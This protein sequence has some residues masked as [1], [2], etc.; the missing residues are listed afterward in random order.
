MKEEKTIWKG[1]RSQWTNLG[2]YIFCALTFYLVI[3]VIAGFITY[4]KTKY[5]TYKITDERIIERFGIFSKT[6]D[7]LEL[8]RIRDVRQDEPFILGLFGMVNII[9]VTTDR[10][11]GVVCLKGVPKSE[12]LK[13]KIRDLIKDGAQRR[14]LDIV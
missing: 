4:L 9:F 5:F 10:T 6:E 3:P 7:D 14:E 13:E 1:S 12:N 8:F 2:T 11:D